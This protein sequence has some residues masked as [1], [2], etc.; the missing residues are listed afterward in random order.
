MKKIPRKNINDLVLSFGLVSRAKISTE[1]ADKCLA[2]LVKI[3][4]I[5]DKHSED[6]KAIETIEDLAEIEECL[7]GCNKALEQ[8]LNETI[9]LGGVLKR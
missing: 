9:R 1:T 4:K 3:E 5:R 2:Q 7:L 8:W 6:L